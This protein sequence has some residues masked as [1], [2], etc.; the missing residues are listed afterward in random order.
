[1]VESQP[2]GL[3]SLEK[4]SGDEEKAIGNL[5]TVQKRRKSNLNLQ[6]DLNTIKQSLIVEAFAS[7]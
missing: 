1:M 3:K 4:A 5:G 7:P 6:G 2:R